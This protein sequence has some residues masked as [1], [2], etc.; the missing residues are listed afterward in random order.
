MKS[1]KERGKWKREEGLGISLGGGYSLKSRGS[2]RK[3]TWNWN[4]TQMPSYLY[5]HFPFLYFNL[6]SIT[7]LNSNLTFPFFSFFFLFF[8]FFNLVKPPF[9]FSNFKVIFTYPL[10]KLI[11]RYIHY[12]STIIIVIFVVYKK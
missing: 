5:S 11:S 12:S 3:P 9:T 4:K 7:T 10:L 1:E 2:Q 8:L 6:H